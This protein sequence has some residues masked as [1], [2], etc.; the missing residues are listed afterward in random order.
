M[1][2][3]LT[4]TKMRAF[5]QASRAGSK[6]QSDEIVHEQAQYELLTTASNLLTDC[7]EAPLWQGTCKFTEG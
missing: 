5:T 7:K 6:M 1:Q 2:S 3:V 4:S